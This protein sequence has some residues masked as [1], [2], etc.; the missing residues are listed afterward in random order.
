MLPLAWFFVGLVICLYGLLL[1]SEMRARAKRH[2]RG[3]PSLPY[4]SQARLDSFIVIEPDLIIVHLTDH[5][6]STGTP[7]LPD[8]CQVPVSELYSFLARSP[9]RSVFVFYSSTSEPVQWSQV[10][11]IT[12]RLAI[13]NAYV[14]KGGLEGWLRKH[15]VEGMA[16]A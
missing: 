11:R 12:N 2:V 15:P 3:C 8:A 4:I 14:L 6:G 1:Y 9:Q 10:E 16:T 13:P 5:P 7:Q